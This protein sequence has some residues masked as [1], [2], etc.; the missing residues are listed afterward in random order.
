MMEKNNLAVIEFAIEALT[1]LSTVII[2][3]SHAQ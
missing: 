2:V 3:D 1:L